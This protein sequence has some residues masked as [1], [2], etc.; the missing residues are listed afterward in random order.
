MDFYVYILQSDK[1]QSFY[2]GQTN[3][4]DE[5]L[6]RHN[7]GMEKYTSRKMPWKIFWKTSLPSRAEA[8]RLEK[9]LKNLKSTKRLLDFV[10]K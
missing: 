5:R 2:I 1:D 10:S 8:M 7:L 3:N 6:K 4:L 9:K